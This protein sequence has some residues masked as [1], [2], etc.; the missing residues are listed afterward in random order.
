[1]LRWPTAGLTAYEGGSLRERV[2]SADEI[3][4]LWGWLGDGA[5]PPFHADVLR[6]ELALGARCGEIAGIHS[7]EINA[8]A[9]LWTL[10]PSRSKNKKARVTPIVGIARQI[11]ASCRE[12]QRGASSAGSTDPSY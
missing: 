9:W 10:P 11:H 7:G 2:L 8:D 6:L 3:K 4:T 12:R 1:M 5:M